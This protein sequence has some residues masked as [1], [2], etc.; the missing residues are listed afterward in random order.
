MIIPLLKNNII[1][2]ILENSNENGIGILFIGI[3]GYLSIYHLVLYFQNKIP[4]YLYYSLFALFCFLP[5]LRRIDNV[6]FEDFFINNAYLFKV[7]H[8]PFQTFSIIFYSL[9][10]LSIL[11]FKK[12][13]YSFY[14]ISKWIIIITSVAICSAIFIDEF[15]YQGLMRFIYLALIFP[16]FSILTLIS[17]PLILKTKTGIK[18]HI[19]LGIISL[20]LLTSILFYKSINISVEDSNKYFYLFYF[21]A[22]LENIFFTLAIGYK[23]QLV[24]KELDKANTVLVKKMSENEELKHQVNIEMQKQI[25]AL[26]EQIKLKNKI[27]ELALISLRSQ[28]NPHFIFNALNSIKHYIINN[29]PK[30]AAHYLTKFSKLIRKILEASDIKEIAL[31]E[32]LETTQLYVTIEN[33]RFSNEINFKINIDKKINISTIKVPPLFLQP[34][35][36]NAIW[37]GLSSKKGA[38]KITISIEKLSS[39]FVEI[40]IEDNGIGR[41][42]SAKIKSQKSIQRKSIGINL[43]KERLNGFVKTLKNNFLIIYEDLLDENKKVIGTK[44]V[45]NI[46]LK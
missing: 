13:F 32:E 10:I 25:S 26:K 35:L 31:N 27:D 11:N 9:F 14:I 3:L 18:F 29:E 12:E 38:K 39:E 41:E 24:N 5:T 8:F 4:Y 16:V 21:G 42:A 19:I 45:L 40:I 34:F 7:L 20:N 22:I 15:L 46:P 28:M 23:Q 17:I 1:K 43:T 37:H 2:T 6:F 36:E 44:V 33:I 30:N